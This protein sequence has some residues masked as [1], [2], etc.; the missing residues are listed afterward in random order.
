MRRGDILW[1]PLPTSKVRLILLKCI[2]LYVLEDHPS[3]QTVSY[4]A[5]LIVPALKTCDDINIA[6]GSEQIVTMH[7]LL[8]V[9][10]SRASAKHAPPSDS[11]PEVN[12]NL[13]NNMIGVFDSD[14]EFAP[15]AEHLEGL[16]VNPDRSYNPLW[17]ENNLD[18]GDTSIT[19][20][21]PNP[22]VV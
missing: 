2:S 12:E 5:N 9:A 4:D 17:F 19:V 15:Y 16:S 3:G 20:Y 1:L 13:K 6:A 14:S 8:G 21:R 10:L 18:L 22:D 7:E 11:P